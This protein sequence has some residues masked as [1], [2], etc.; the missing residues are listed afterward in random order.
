MN[1]VQ[2]HLDLQYRH[3]YYCQKKA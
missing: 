1:K 3:F 2:L